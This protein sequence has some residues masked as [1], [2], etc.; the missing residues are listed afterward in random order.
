MVTKKLTKTTNSHAEIVNSKALE[1]RCINSPWHPV[2]YSENQQTSCLPS[3]PVDAMV[4]FCT[5]ALISSPSSNPTSSKYSKG[6]W[7]R[8]HHNIPQPSSS[9]VVNESTLESIAP[10][11]TIISRKLGSSW[12]NSYCWWKE[13]TRGMYR[14]LEKLDGHGETTY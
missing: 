11:A 6:S 9:C 8:I 3:V 10:P 13:A 4:A 2:E 5:S 14:T 12:N 7:D 1:H